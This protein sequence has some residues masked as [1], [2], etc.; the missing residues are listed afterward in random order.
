MPYNDNT[1]MSLHKPLDSYK[2]IYKELHH[3]HVT[4]KLDSFVLTSQV[5]LSANQSTVKDIRSNEKTRDNLQKTIRNKKTLRS[6]LIFMIVALVVLA[7]Y[8]IYQLTLIIDN[9]LSWVLIP[10]SII[11]IVYF[12]ILISKSINP[13]IKLLKADKEVILKKLEALF[14]DAWQQMQPLNDLFYEG[15]SQELFQQT[16]PLIRMDQVFDSK[17]LD[18]L[19][20]KFGLGDLDALDRS[21]LYVQSGEIKGNP[22]YI[23]EDLVHKLGTKTYT[24][25]ITISWTTTSRVNGRTVTTTR[26]QVLSASINRPYPLYTEQ[27]YLVYGNDAAPDL[28]FSRTDSDAENMSEKQIEKHVDKTIKKL[29]KKSRKSISQG[30]NYTV[31]GNSEFEVL[32][33]AINRNNE[34]QFRLLF[35]PLAQTELLK[36][37]KE[38]TIGFG[39][40][41]DFIKHKKINIIIPEHLATIKLDIAPSYFASYDFE[42]I[43]KKFTEYQ[44]AYFKHVYFAFAPVLAIPLYQQ[45]MTQ[46]YIYKDLYSSYVSFFE[47]E[48]VVNQMNIN[49]FKHPE[50]ATRNILKTSILKSSDHK[51]VVK[52]TAYGYKSVPRIE[53]VSKMGGDGRM[54]V[55][56]IHWHEYIPVNQSTNVEINVTP[57]DQPLTPRQR[58]EQV[59]ERL[60]NREVDAKDM[61]LIKNFAARVLIPQKN[62]KIKT[63]ERK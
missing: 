1:D 31:I 38:K 43:K 28:M 35:T 6:F 45:T 40:D 54:H 29:E 48:R 24:G 56:P 18:Y 15:M 14:K 5:D 26:S 42:D 34:V 13:K 51:D 20:S 61:I 11:L 52:V 23:A 36:L 8:S 49:Q 22:F 32:F 47:H 27:S 4:E 60:K 59:F 44:N 37:M 2:N 10:V 25:S 21:T 19:V 55:I 50:S 39:D 16:I 3:K 63:N 12:I 7:I 41:F 33:H 57:E 46:E 53:Y 17:R 58:V 9:V 62:D 30:T